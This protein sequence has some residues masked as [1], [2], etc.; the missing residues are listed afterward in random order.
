MNKI[1]YYYLKIKSLNYR[2]A[3]GYDATL[4]FNYGYL[5]AL[6]TQKILK[7]W[8]YNSL[9]KVFSADNNDGIFSIDKKGNLMQ[10]Q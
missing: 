7:R 3:L 8:E 2:L 6:L 9:L 10:D 5:R 4:D 1:Y